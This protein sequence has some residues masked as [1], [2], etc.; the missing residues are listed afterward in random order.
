MQILYANIAGVQLKN[1]TKAFKFFLMC[2]RLQILA[3][4]K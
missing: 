4:T 2:K 3:Y 1:I